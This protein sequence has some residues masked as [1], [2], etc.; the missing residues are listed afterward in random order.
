MTRRLFKRHRFLFEELEGPESENTVTLN[1]QEE[2][3]ET[4]L[5]NDKKDK[6]TSKIYYRPTQDALDLVAYLSSLKGA[7][8]PLD[9]AP[10]YQ[11]FTSSVPENANDL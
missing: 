9:E 11:P 6:T 5:K 3:N 7:N 2:L 1:I 4:D 10:I 8:Y